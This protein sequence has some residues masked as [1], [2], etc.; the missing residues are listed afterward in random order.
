[1]MEEVFIRET[2][3]IRGNKLNTELG[4]RMKLEENHVEISLENMECCRD[5]GK[6]L[7]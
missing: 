1:M 3:E 7:L 2:R 5:E 4:H 6:L